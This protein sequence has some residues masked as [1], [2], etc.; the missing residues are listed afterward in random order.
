MGPTREQRK[1]VGEQ[2]T[3]YC[4]LFREPK[5][6]VRCFVA[7]TEADET[8][9]QGAGMRRFRW[10]GVAVVL[11]LAGALT[12][13]V[14]DRVSAVPARGRCRAT[15]LVANNGDGTVSTIDTKAGT[16]DPTG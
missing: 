9:R 16:K 4:W 5:C 1:G 2:R 12:D 10:L 13:V 14:A 7:A 11:G 6:D 8:A 15:A 3:E